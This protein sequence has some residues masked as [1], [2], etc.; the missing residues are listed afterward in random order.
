M[1]TLLTLCTAFVLSFCLTGQDV[2]SV[3]LQETIPLSQLAEDFGAENVE[4]S[5]R[6]YKMLYRTIDPFGA[7]TVAS[8]MLAIP[9]EEGSPI[10][11]PITVYNHGTVSNREQVPSRVG[12]QERGLVNVIA[13]NGFITIAPDYLGLG[14]NPGLHPY[15]HAETEAQAG[16]DMILAIRNWLHDE[17]IPFADQL[18]TTG[19]SQGGH[20]SMALQ[21]KLQE[22]PT[23]LLPVLSAGA[24]LSGPYSISDVMVN[25]LFN[26]N[27]ETLPAYLAYTYISYNYVY[28]IYDSLAQVFVQP[29]LEPVEAF[30]NETIDLGQ[31][32]T[33]LYALLNSAGD[34]LVDMFQDS[35]T[36]GLQEDPN[37]PVVMAL[38]DNDTYNFG[39]EA[40]TLLVYC[41]ED[42]QVPY[43]N[44]LLADSVM[45]GLGGD[46]VYIYNGGARDHG[47]CILPAALQMLGFFKG[48]SVLDVEEEVAATTSL[49]ISPNP[50]RA[51]G[52]LHFGAAFDEPTAFSLVDVTGRAVQSGILETGSQQMQLSQLA[53]GIYYLYTRG[54]GV[55]INKISIH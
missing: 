5:V 50:L 43:Q 36:N 16:Y 2:V 10:S 47:G 22:D 11:F 33:T 39:P 29:Y 14:D 7:P 34:E 19:Y 24:H 35:L 26:P 17:E 46:Q 8:G 21:Q 38:R 3:E 6:T 9:Y 49:S 41:T 37:H 4:F 28:Q 54:K 23:D 27:T 20:A 40:P 32:N 31:L 12:V 45:R 25:V 52:L 13:A 42:E 51:G 48:F 1:R 53:S 18:F 55:T 44:A 15:V 30:A